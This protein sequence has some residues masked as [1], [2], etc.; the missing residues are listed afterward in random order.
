MQAKLYN[1]MTAILAATPRDRTELAGMLATLCSYESWLGPYHPQT[2][3][4]MAQ[5]AF[6]YWQVRE[7]DYARPLLERIVSD[8]GRNLGREHECCVSR[9][10]RRSEIC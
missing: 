3:R 7:F 4:F 6:A 5:V 9:Q 2:L 8:V 1:N 10:L